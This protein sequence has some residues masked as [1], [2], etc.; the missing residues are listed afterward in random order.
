MILQGGAMCSLAI[1]NTPCQSFS[2]VTAFQWRKNKL[3]SKPLFSA[4]VA[5]A[6]DTPVS[7]SWED[8]ET[9]LSTFHSLHNLPK[10]EPPVLT[11]YRDTNGWCPF[12]ERVWLCLHA[13]G[14]PYRERLISL[15]DK[16]EWYKELVPTTQVPAVLIHGST[17]EEEA[18]TVTERR[19]VWDSLDVMKAL[20]EAF[21]DTKPMILDTPEYEL[22]SNLVDDVTR[23]GVG[24][25]YAGRNATLT[26]E[27][28]QE[29]RANFETA[30]NELEALLLQNGGPFLLGSELSGVDAKIVPTL[31][32]WRYQL[33]ITKEFSIMESR[34]ALTA[35][36]DAM[37]AFAP[38]SERVRGDEYSWV[39]TA[40]MFVRYFGGGDDDESQAQIARSETKGKELT[41][42]FD[43]IDVKDCLS[44]FVHEAAAKLISNR[45]AIVNDCTNKEPKSQSDIVRSSSLDV[46]E[47]MLQFTTHILL[48]TQEDSSRE[49]ENVVDVLKRART[50]TL[51][52]S[53]LELDYEQKL[54]AALAAKTVASR[55]CVP[56]DMS[57]PAA[58]ILRAVLSIISQRLEKE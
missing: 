33:P 53:L 44:R 7:S 34:P 52:S 2:P 57:A 55:L 9:D 41:V 1:L 28:M 3:P 6:A 23:A 12:C 54:D 10:G 47:N 24:F 56:R 17:E 40:A 50:I 48:P 49:E 26:P 27:D 15:S 18:K 42:A 29:R 37:D 46:A 35:W 32:R 19:L 45:D 20:D 14:L 21:P 13:K 58:K 39:V 11:F 51:P 16:P 22:A 25:V 8:L 36:F 30:L 43:E 38:Y 4:S 31:E 5:V